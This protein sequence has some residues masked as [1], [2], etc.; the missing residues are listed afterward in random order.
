MPDKWSTI[1]CYQGLGYLFIEKVMK[2]FIKNWRILKD[3][4]FILVIIII[5][6]QIINFAASINRN[7]TS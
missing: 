1:R 7:D 5:I 6:L 4:Q 3:I 2:F